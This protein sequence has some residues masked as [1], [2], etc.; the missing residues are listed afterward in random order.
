MGIIKS[1]DIKNLLPFHK[2]GKGVPESIGKEDKIAELDPNLSPEEQVYVAHYLGYADIL[3]AA[4]VP[5]EEPATQD[6]ED[7]IVEM[8][9]S[10]PEIQGPAEGDG[11]A[12]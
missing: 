3:L 1:F 12:A 9:V 8:P 7:K 6:K 2:P 4:Q 5:G 11:E 10:G